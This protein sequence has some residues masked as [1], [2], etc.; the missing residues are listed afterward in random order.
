MI[1][2]K[3]YIYDVRAAE[4]VDAA[5]AVLQRYLGQMGLDRTIYC[6]L[7]DMPAIGAEVGHAV[8][9][10][11]PQ[12]WLDYYHERKYQA[13]DPVIKTVMSTDEAFWWSD[14]HK[15]VPMGGHEQQILEEAEDAQVCD[16]MAVAVHGRHGAVTA[17]GAASSSGGVE[18]SHYLLALVRLMAHEFQDVFVNLK[19]DERRHLPIALTRREIEVLRWLARGKSVPEATTILSIDGSISEAT[20]RFHV[21]NIYAK[22]EVAS[23]P[24]AVAKS[25]ARG[26]ITFA[27]LQGYI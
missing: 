25:L 11:Y 15:F 10:N 1:D 23:A 7:T 19:A 24:Q 12:E 5:F 14:M 22:L 9:G 21:K 13:T 2:I 8:F 17:L 16:G 6:I 3:Q 27:D 18:H 26:I 20:V 4:T